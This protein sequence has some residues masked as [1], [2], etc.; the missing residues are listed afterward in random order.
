MHFSLDQIPYHSTLIVP[1]SSEAIHVPFMANFVV[2]AKRIDPMEARLRVFC[3]TDDREDK[4][5]E[6]QEHFSEVAKSRD[7][8]VLEGKAQ[9]VEM[10]GN[11]IPVTKSGEQLQ[12]CFKA[13]RENRL[14]FSV[15]V[16]DQHADNVGR[17][18]FMREPKV[19]KGEASQQPICILNIVLPE[20]IMPDTISI[21]DDQRDVIARINVQEMQK[22]LMPD[23]FN[24]LGEMRIADI[25]NVLGEDWLRLSPEIG[26]SEIEIQEI[27]ENN[28]D[29]TAK[30]GQ[31]MLRLF[32]S[33]KNSDRNILENGLKKIGRDD[34]IKQC[35]KFN[36]F[37]E[38]SNVRRHISV[39]DER[40]LMKDSESIEELA[41]TEDSRLKQLHEREEMKYSAEEKIIEDSESEED[42]VI[43]RTV[44][45]RR[46]QIEKRLSVERQFPASTQKKEI[47][48]EITTIKRQSLIEDKKAHHEEEIILNTP[49][50]NVIKSVAI[51][52]P[53]L[54]LKSG[55]RDS[56]EITKDVFEKELKDKMKV[57]IKGMEADMDDDD[58]LLDKEP[59]M[60]SSKIH[61]DTTETEK[62]S[63][64]DEPS[65]TTVKETTVV[66][67]TS[68]PQDGLGQTTTKTTTTTTTITQKRVG[69]Q[70]S[71]DEEEDEDYDHDHEAY[72]LREAQSDEVQSERK[73]H[74]ADA[75]K[76]EVMD[77]SDKE[78]MQK[79]ELQKEKIEHSTRMVDDILENATQLVITG[80]D[81]K[82][83]TSQ[84]LDEERRSAE[85]EII[86]K[87]QG[88]I[89]GQ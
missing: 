27:I 22:R 8:E 20:E 58:L 68:E 80:V 18:L 45:E 41:L 57:T 38:S 53:V 29:S 24:Y 54:K 15:R 2:F 61:I 64:F 33:R 23:N 7:V 1:P 51:A 76:R 10:A 25:S 50:D 36:N 37:A 9:F 40:D 4:T 79:L 72:L 83:V 74:I 31:A 34:V 14:P 75:I 87:A 84:M 42:E 17:A 12:L 35:I 49:V 13:F 3:M 47:V 81:V 11:L 56:K 82:A 32:Q 5:L 78:L 77:K 59:G 88:K 30:Q 65:S 46:T 71:D 63:R 52:E 73:I 67:T 16:K 69:F 26:V 70:Y 55:D 85:R 62:V 21:L 19:A 6:Q 43:R 39:E 66:E 44:A 86:S 89:L 48:E 28:P 60:V